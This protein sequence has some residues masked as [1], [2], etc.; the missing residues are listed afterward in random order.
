[1]HLAAAAAIA[2]EYLQDF[3]AGGHIDPNLAYLACGPNKVR[4]A[5]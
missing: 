2:R 1:M 3:I 5:R 4:R